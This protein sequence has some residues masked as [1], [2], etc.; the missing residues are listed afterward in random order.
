MSIDFALSAVRQYAVAAFMCVVLGCGLAGAYTM[1]A[2]KNYESTAQLMLQSAD[3]TTS[4]STGA[5]GTTT[6][7]FLQAQLPTY[8]E[9]AQSRQVLIS[10]TKKVGF[11]TT[12][13]NLKQHLTFSVPSDT[14]ILEVTASWDSPS[15]AAAI[16]NAVSESF[17]KKIGNLDQQDSSGSEIR[18]D[19]YE[20]ARLPTAPSGSS[21]LV[22][23]IGIIGGAAAGIIVAFLLKL[24]D[25]YIRHLREIEDL[26]GAPV[27]AV[28]GG[29]A[30]RLRD[31]R[32]MR[33]WIRQ[34]N[35]SGISRSFRGLYVSLGLADSVRRNALFTVTSTEDCANA[36]N[37]AWGLATVGTNS[38]LRCA[39]TSTNARIQR[40]LVGLRSRPDIARSGLPDVCQIKALRAPVNAVVNAEIVS[41]VLADIVGQGDL[42]MVVTQ[43]PDSDPN[44][45]SLMGVGSSVVLVVSPRVSRDRLASAAKL[46]RDAG[47]P[48]H[49]VV[50]AGISADS[51]PEAKNREWLTTL[52]GAQ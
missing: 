44:V 31:K 35:V 12:V 15:G 4:T 17:A 48:L 36:A 39:I 33:A 40:H 41:V 28:L 10:A 37:V 32:Q 3:T 24:R 18:A 46:I 1:F 43:P 13:E 50:I 26:A 7:Q 19:L 22:L 8:V 38:G 2:P 11:Q 34:A 23:F 5:D 47:S 49:S 27:A 29:H 25:P 52:Q 20:P 16:A 14:V 30:E 42:V 21:A 9:Y 45:R 51:P 6:N